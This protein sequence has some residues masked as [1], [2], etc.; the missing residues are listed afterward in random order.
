MREGSSSKPESTIN[1][2]IKRLIDWQGKQKDFARLTKIPASTL[3]SIV[4]TR[5]VKPDTDTLQKILTAYPQVSAEWLHTGRGSMLLNEARP[6]PMLFEQSTDYAS[7]S[8]EAV[9]RQTEEQLIQRIL[10]PLQDDLD[11]L[12]AEKEKIREVIRRLKGGFL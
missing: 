12:E 7:S 6:V 4:S 10:K 9:D 2:R 8:K 5:Q 1:Q 3:S 11:R